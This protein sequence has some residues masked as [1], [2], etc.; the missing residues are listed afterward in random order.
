M[1]E[2]GHTARLAYFDVT[3][4]EQKHGE[5]GASI[6]WQVRVCYSARHPDAGSDDRVRVSNEPWSVEFR[7]GETDGP[8]QWQ[9]IREL[10]HDSGWAPQYATKRLAL[11]ECN[12]GWMAVRHGNPH[13]QWTGLRYAPANSGDTVVWR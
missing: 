11:G 4:L 6:G 1:L 9:A 13:L 12:E 3:A 7:D 2:Y 5:D 8:T 10:P